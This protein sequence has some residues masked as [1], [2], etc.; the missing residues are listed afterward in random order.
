MQILGCQGKAF[1]KEDLH[2]AS[3]HSLQHTQATVN[4][5]TE[6]LPTVWP[7][8]QNK[9]Y[10]F[11]SPE[12]ELLEKPPW[13]ATEH[14]GNSNLVDNILIVLSTQNSPTSA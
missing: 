1:P 13:E 8:T 3:H 11:Y 4:Q 6:V 14:N 9:Y 10:L 7:G 2:M 12:K 5:I